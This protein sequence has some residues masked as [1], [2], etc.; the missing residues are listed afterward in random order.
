MSK[1]KEL[2]N[3]LKTPTTVTK[4]DMIGIY[5]GLACLFFNLAFKG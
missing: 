4:L 1:L 2:Y 3:K 5:F